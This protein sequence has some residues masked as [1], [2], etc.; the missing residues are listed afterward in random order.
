MIVVSDTTP[1]NYLV[2]VDTIELLPKLFREVCVPPQVMRELLHP[3]TPDRVRQ[4]AQAPPNWLKILGPTSTLAVTSSLD[5]GEA[6]AISLAKE[7][8]AAAILIDERRATKI[9]K[10]E[11]LTVIRT[12]ALLELAAERKLINLAVTLEKLR[13]TT[14]RI[15]QEH[16]DAALARIAATEQH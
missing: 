6:E 5:R 11:G 1:L 16:I 13:A 15:S 8:K 12:L 2:L 3:R 9:A 4:W 7:L 14:F 10:S